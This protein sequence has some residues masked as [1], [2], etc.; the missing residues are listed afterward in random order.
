MGNSTILITGATSGIGYTTAEYLASAGYQLV[1]TGRNK[2]KLNEIRF[3]INDACVSAYEMDLTN[4]ETIEGMF[5]SIKEQGIRFDGLIHCAGIEGSLSPVRSIKIKN[6]DLL[7]KLHYEA[8]VEMGRLF[9]KKAISNEGSSIIAISSLASLMCQKNT[10]D[11]S[12]SKAAVNAAIKVMSKEFQKRNIRVNG[13]MPANVDTPMC[14]NLKSVVDIEI[15]QP[16]GMIEPVQ[17]AYLAEFLLSD[18]AKF[19]T[20]ALIP[21]SAGMEY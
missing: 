17:I 2:E 8:F 14:D 5:D 19:I 7:M 16:M 11:Y 18:K 21:V 3:K 1:L 20:G 10:V 15:I 13:I 4:T 6:L 9:Y 12:A